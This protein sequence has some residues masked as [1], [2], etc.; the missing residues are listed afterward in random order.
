MSILALF[1]SDI[2]PQTDGAQSSRVPILLSDDPI[3]APLL[4]VPSLVPSSD[5]LHLTVGYSHTPVTIDTKF[6]PEE[7]P[8]EIEDFEAYKILDTRSTSSHSLASS[9]FTAPLSPDHPLTQTLPTPAPT[10][11]S[12]H[13]RTARM[14]VRTQLTLSPGMSAR[15]AEASALSP[16]LFRKRY[17]SSYETPSPSSS[18]NLP[19]Q[20]RYQSTSELVED[21]KEESSDSDDERDRSK[22][23]GPG[24]EEEAAPE[25]QQQAVQAKD[26]AVNEP[27]GFGY[28]ALRCHELVIGDGEMPSTFEVGQSCRSVPKH[29]G[30]NRTSAFRQP[31]L[32]TRVD[33]EDGR[34]YTD[35][36]N[37]VPP[38]APVQILPSLEWSSCSLPVSPSSPI[39]PT[40]V[41]SPVTT[42]V[43]TIAV[44]EDKFLEVATQLKLYGSIL[45]DH[46]QRLDA[47]PPTLFEGYD[48]DLME[49]YTRSGRENHD[50]RM[51]I[52]EERRERL[53]LTDRVARMERR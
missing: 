19:I 44:D 30:A 11:V 40:L 48:R 6:E 43:A 27:L 20:K 18:S 23:E 16:S 9:N 22:D 2:F 26:I 42:P 25:G 28:M 36:L 15:I 7:G 49:L 45:H 41:A 37:Y 50:L 3:R 39:V 46:T 38:V 17:R 53:E 24:S 31:T 14:V 12:F 34:V 21:I 35:I 29:E 47:L 51:Q 4:V 5:D 32:V 1:D 33:P 10:R 8:S 13:H 52:A